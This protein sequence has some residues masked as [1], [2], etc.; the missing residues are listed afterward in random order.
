MTLRCH[1]K[2]ERYYINLYYIQYLKFFISQSHSP[3]KRTCLAKINLNPLNRWKLSFPSAGL[4]PAV[5]E[6]CTSIR[7]RRAKVQ[8]DSFT[9]CLCGSH[10][11]S[12]LKVRKVCVVFFGGGGVIGMWLR[13]YYLFLFFALLLVVSIG[14]VLCC[15]V[16]CCVLCKYMQ[17]VL[18]I[19][20]CIYQHL[21]VG[22]P[23]KP[24]G[25]FKLTPL[26]GTM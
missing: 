14:W 8:V 4:S 24:K 13:V 5:I 22:L 23:I 6:P 16:L 26:N 19:Y 2:V 25:W 21:P 18:L 1:S 11:C 7:L 20:I 12:D 9:K 17:H 3:Q 15:V 10:W